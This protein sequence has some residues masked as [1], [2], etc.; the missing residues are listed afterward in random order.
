MGPAFIEITIIICLAA[1]LS[2][3]FRLFKQ[4]AILAYIL[5]GILIGLLGFLN[6]SNQEFLN[7]LAQLG[8]TFLLFTLGLE[9][10]IK[11]FA[12]I[13]RV[14]FVVAGV[15][16]LFSFLAGYITALFFGLGIASAVYIGITLIFSSTV[17]VIKLI[18]ERKEFHSLYGKIAVG[19]L[20]IQDLLAIGILILLSG[21]S[22]QFTTAQPIWIFAQIITKGVILLGVVWLLGSYVFP[23]I[24][25]KLAQSTET[26]FLASIAWV[27]GL[28]ALVSSIGF[29]VEIGGFLAGLALAN[30]LVNYQIIA[31]AKILQ[32]FFIILFFVLLG[33]SMTFAT[34]FDGILVILLPALTLSIL[35]LVVKPI[36]VMFI[37]GIMGFKKR[38]SFLT[39]ISLAQISEFSLITVFLGERLGHIP[40]EIVSIVTLCAIITFTLSTYLVVGSKNIYK[41]LQRYLSFLELVTVKREDVIESS[42]GLSDLKNHVVLIGGDQMGQSILESLEEMDIDVVVVDFD[43]EILKKLKDLSS[44][45]TGKKSHRLYGDISDLDI[46][47]RAKL[48]SAKLVISTNPDLEDNLLILKELKH[49]NRRAKVVV[50]AF[51]TAEAKTLYKAGADYV[52]LPHLAGGRQIAKLIAE[53]HLDKVESLKKKDLEYIN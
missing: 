42:D 9:I 51:D 38:T 12:S 29:S 53:N 6:A 33:A 21:F 18:S 20:L 50:M 34:S 46:Q 17:I 11:N 39:G 45:K 3:V 10:R 1:L 19:V 49:E 28:S 27:F 4:P 40:S 13:S 7:T 14:V 36:I 15:Q 26:L 30:S 5:T 23:K 16:M 48:D 43:P 25:E 52:V 2:F 41:S 44:G 8:I 47:E 22:Q 32:D 24:M 35:A 31:R 37:M